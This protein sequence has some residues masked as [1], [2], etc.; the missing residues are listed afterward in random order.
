LTSSAAIPC[1]TRCYE[2]WSDSAK[3]EGEVITDGYQ[4]FYKHWL[5]SSSNT[6]FLDTFP[7]ELSLGPDGVPLLPFD[8]SN[9]SGSQILVTESYNCMLRRLLHLR[10]EDSRDNKGAVLT[11][12]PGIGISKSNDHFWA[13]VTFRWFPPP[14]LG[15]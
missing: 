12:Q 10:S 5:K 7:Y 3:E 4:E 6:N 8:D 13:P 15:A 14:N 2:V 11:G 1:L 9:T